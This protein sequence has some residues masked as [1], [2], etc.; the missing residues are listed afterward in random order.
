MSTKTTLKRIALVAVSAMG[1]GLLSVLPAKAAEATPTA[2]VVGKTTEDDTVALTAGAYTASTILNANG[3]SAFS[4]GA[5]SS[6]ELAVIPIG[7]A[8]QA[9]ATVRLSYAGIGIFHTSDAMA[10]SAAGTAEL[11]SAFTAPVTAGTYTI[12]GIYDEDDDYTSTD[13]QRTFS[14][15]MTVTA[16]SALSASLSTKYH[17]EGAVAGTSTTDLYPVVV[18]K[19]AGT[20]AGNI[21]VTL[22]RAN[23]T[24]FGDTSATVYAYVTGP[25]L[26][27]ITADQTDLNGDTVTDVRSDSLANPSDGI[28]N[29]NVTADGTAG[30]GTVT[31]Y[32]IDAAGARIDLGTEAFT[33]HG[34]ASTLTATQNLTWARSA[35]NTTGYTGTAP[36]ATDTAAAYVAVKDSQGNPVTAASLSC[37]SADT[38]VIASCTI[39]EDDGTS[40][41]GYG[42][43]NYYVQV[44]SGAPSASGQS[45]TVYVR[46]VDPAGNGTTYLVTANMTFK[47]SSRTVFTTTLTL[48][49]A[50]YAPGEY[51]TLTVTSKDSA[52]NP[53]ADSWSAGTVRSCVGSNVLANKQ[54]SG[55]LP[56]AADGCYMLNGVET[57]KFYVPSISG[58]FSLN[59]VSSYDGVTPISV[60]ATVSSTSTDVAIAAAQAAA[61]AAADAAAEAIDA[62]NAATD[63]ANLSAEAADAATVAAEEARD[64]ADA[65][66]AAVEALATEVATLM[67]ALKAQITTLANTVAKIAK[68]VKA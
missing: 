32:V 45:T 29:V 27:D 55:A 36:A 31:I 25:G 35:G 16:L 2:V 18:S 9:A 47:I 28:F 56:V 1:F 50:T 54:I 5:G 40:L 49:K 65:A 53:V 41:Y 13:D 12:N 24:A 14:V 58:E 60:K 34:A 23:N 6:V 64:A 21:T 3:I 39:T 17:A 33:F 63:A 7:G 38:L 44:T 30:A 66:T 42:R 22:K 48:D 51:A 8:S 10:G 43:G 11:L 37:V 68:K 20:N 59:T 61:D 67:A 52:G 15:T 19:D 26:L 4:V 46:M 62:A 57:Y